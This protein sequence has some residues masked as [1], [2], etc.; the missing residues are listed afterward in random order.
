MKAS[1]VIP[2]YNCVDLLKISMKSLEQ[3]DI[4]LDDFEVIVVDDGSSDGTDE[5]LK[6]YSGML[7]LKPIINPQNL[8]RAVSRNRGIEIAKN[9]LIIFLDSDIEVKKD[10]IRTHLG[11]QKNRPSAAVGKILYHPEL[12]INSLMS[13]LDKRGSAKAYSG[14][15]IPGKYFRTTNASVPRDILIE[16]GCFDEHFLHYGGEDTELGIRLEQKLPIYSLPEAIG[17]NRHWRGLDELL[18]IME[19]YGEYSLPYLFQKHPFFKKEMKLDHTGKKTLT[20]FIVSL[21][22]SEPIYRFL[23]YLAKYELTP[24][25]IYTYLLYRNSR[26]GYIKSMHDNVPNTID[27]LKFKTSEK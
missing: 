14:S 26:F 27:S 5:F 2:S 8:G 18:N 6:T 19:V 25:V 16:I 23:K 3:Q 21:C 20:N 4:S 9:E 22:C 17:Y 24:N 7:K 12:E 11:A 13:Y 10:F 1:V 15:K